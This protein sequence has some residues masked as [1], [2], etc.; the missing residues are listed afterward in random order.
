MSRR[1]VCKNCKVFVDGAECPFC[2][3]NQFVTNWK[4]RLFILDPEKSFIADK[5]EAKHAAEYAIKVR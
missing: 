4:G 1:K 5:V 2:K 3:G